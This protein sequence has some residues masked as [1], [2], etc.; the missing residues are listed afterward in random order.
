M[1]LNEMNRIKKYKW[2]SIALLISSMLFIFSLIFDLDLYEMFEEFLEEMD[3]LELDEIVLFGFPVMFGITLDMQR[4]RRKKQ[5]EI[6]LGEQHLKTLSNT[7]RTA[8]DIV[9]NFL[10]SIQLYILKAEDEKL[11]PEDV[12]KLNQLIETTAQ[13]LNC[14]EEPLLQKPEDKKPS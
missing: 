13:R 2:T 14:L 12:K 5:R 3:H 9:N 6:I 4:H 7:L 8:Q 1:A 11:D 10:N